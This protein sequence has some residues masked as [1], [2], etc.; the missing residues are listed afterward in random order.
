MKKKLFFIGIAVLML[1]SAC[2]GGESAPPAQAV[3]RIGENVDLGGY[4]P[5]SNMSPFVRALIFN[6]LVELDENFQQ[7]PA[8]ADSWHMSQDGRTWT[9]Y[10]RQGVYFHDGTPWNAP[11]AKTNFEHRIARGAA[12]FYQAITQMETPD[13]YTFIVHLNQPMFTLA[14]DLAVPTHGMVSPLA[15]NEEH[16]VTA[17]IGTGAFVLEDWV[18]DSYFT[19]A[20]NPQFFRGQAQIESLHFLVIPDGMARAMALQ[21]G[22]IDMMSGRGALTA[23]E[24]LR[25]RDGIQMITSLSQTSEFIMLNTFDETLSDVRVRRAIAHGVD[26]PSIVS[27]LLED[28][29]LPPVAFFSP[30][31]GD[32]VNPELVLPQYD[33][34]RAKAYLE[35]AGFAPGQLQ[36]E[37]LVDARNEE[38]SV[39]VLLMQEQLRAVGIELSIV[40][41][42]AA[43]ISQ[44]V[45]IPEQNFQLAMRGQYFIPTDDPSIHY[46]N[47]F[48]HRESLHNLY[49]TPA[50]DAMVE[51]LM[52][53][54]DA[55]ERLALHWQLQEYITS[56]VPV[57]MMFHRNNIILANERLEAFTL[58]SGTWQIY[59]GLE[60]ARVGS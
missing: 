26:F 37:I 58:S 2:S 50:L 13:D 41:L 3:L 4:D 39:L 43:A 1:F 19:M 40:Q 48:F 22:E 42:D 10:L 15:Y 49:S 6:T 55:Q 59:R 54:L 8:L 18:P 12:G 30:V 36:L 27:V 47:G 34:Q 57:I 60:T 28:L 24:N 44:R 25:H 20:R 53:S 32:F 23:V 14:S 52:A 31:F 17:P 29:A 33:P 7:S 56:Q 11:G 51:Q 45:S 35:A 38:N 9:F 5:N 21:S 16:Q 46:R